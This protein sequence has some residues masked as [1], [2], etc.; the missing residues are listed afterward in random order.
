LLQTPDLENLHHGKCDRV[1]NK[2]RRRRQRSSLLTT[3]VRQPTSRG[4]LLQ[5]GQ[6]L[7]SNSIQF[8]V[9]LFYN[10]FLLLTRFRLKW[11]VARSVCGSS[12]PS[13]CRFCDS[14][15]IVPTARKQT[16][17]DLARGSRSD[18][19]TVNILANRI[20]NES[21]FAENYIYNCNQHFGIFIS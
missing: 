5:V 14:E 15:Q 1:V 3:P 9:D 13:W 4:C 6:L 11:R 19:P 16:A 2:T 17:L 21:V 12:A 7:L 10:F 20:E 18:R 8:A